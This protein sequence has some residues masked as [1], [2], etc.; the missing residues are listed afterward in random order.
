MDDW[1]SNMA[2]LKLLTLELKPQTVKTFALWWSPQ[3]SW[4][5]DSL[6]SMIYPKAASEGCLLSKKQW[7]SSEFDLDSTNSPAQL[8][9]S[10]QCLNSHLK[11]G[12]RWYQVGYW[13]TAHI[14]K[15]TVLTAKVI[16][17]FLLH[18]TEYNECVKVGFPY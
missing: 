7:L 14:T 16:Y 10:K 12:G 6:H 9:G 5:A 15:C 4:R 18:C 1:A 2:Q 11:S 3:H 8:A 17:F 13:N